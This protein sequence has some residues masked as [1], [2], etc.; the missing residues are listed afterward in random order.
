MTKAE[1]AQAGALHGTYECAGYKLLT[2]GTAFFS[3]MCL[4]FLFVA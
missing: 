4:A 3:A 2:D 1:G